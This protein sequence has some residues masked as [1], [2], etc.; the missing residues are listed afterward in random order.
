MQAKYAFHP[1]AEHFPLM[2]APEFEALKKDIKEHGLQEPICLFEGKILDGRN[3]YN[4]CLE[5][6]IEPRF[7][8]RDFSH[9]EAV[10]FSISQNLQRRHL[11]KSQQA[12]YLVKAGLLGKGGPSGGKRQYRTGDLAIRRISERYGVSHV[13]IYKAIFVSGH[14]GELAAKVLK[15]KLSV[16]KAEK[17]IRDCDKGSESG[18]RDSIGQEVPTKLRLVFS[19]AH[20]LSK[21]YALLNRV[22]DQIQGLPGKTGAEVQAGFRLSITELASIT[23]HAV[24]SKCSGRGCATCG[25]KGWQSVREWESRKAV[26]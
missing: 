10:A 17:I 14:D 8:Q 26:T 19:I 11:T 13:S 22:R 21:A 18:I 23:P 4:A 3:R 12:M 1:L 2:S 5:L 7:E 24:C 25:A 6:G 15:G 9:E 20:D 16:A